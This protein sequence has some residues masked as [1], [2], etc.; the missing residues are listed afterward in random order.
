MDQI[1]EAIL[2]GDRSEETYAGI[3]V[4]RHL[5][6]RDRAQGRGRDVRRDLPTTREGPAP[7]PARRAGAD[8]RARPG[9]GPRRGHGQR[10]QLQHRVDLD[11]R[12]GADLRLPRALRPHLGVRPAPR[13]ALPRRRLRPR[14]RRAAH[15]SRR[16]EV[17]ARHRGR[18]AL[19]RGRARGR[20]GPRR[21]DDGPAAAHLG[22]RDELRR[23]RRAGDRQGQPA[24][25]Q[26]GP[27]HVGGGGLPRAGQQ[28]RLPPAHLARTART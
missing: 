14:G 15:R 26:A 11:L 9:R 22:L 13:P 12:A 1:R 16:H 4:P 21:H 25:A 3:A 27:P 8:A 10:D 28:H 20:R 7:L 23:A 18:R 19:P 24:D 6:R 5:P 2:S 17:E